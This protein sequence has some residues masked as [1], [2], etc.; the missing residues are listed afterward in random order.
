[1]DGSKNGNRYKINPVEIVIFSV[2][3]LIFLNSVYSLFNDST[4]FNELKL[5]TKD[6]NRQPAS[7]KVLENLM[8]NCENTHQS[9]ASERIRI[10]GPLCGIEQ[11]SQGNQKFLNTKIVNTANSY[12]ATVFIEENA[13]KFQTDYIPL[14]TGSN[15][16]KIEHLYS[17]GVNYTQEIEIIKN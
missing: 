1:M 3:A 12:S 2:V 9:I 11:L 6:E 4:S 13:K 14:A 17:S 15:K 7:Y 8:V 5:A 16:I 10:T